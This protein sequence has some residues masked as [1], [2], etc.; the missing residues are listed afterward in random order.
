MLSSGFRRARKYPSPDMSDT[1]CL[2]RGSPQMTNSEEKISLQ[3]C[4]WKNIQL[5]NLAFLKISLNLINPNH[6]KSV[7]GLSLEKV[8]PLKL[9]AG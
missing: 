9:S 7:A 5:G 6:R 3:K 8:D 2:V 1:P 4:I